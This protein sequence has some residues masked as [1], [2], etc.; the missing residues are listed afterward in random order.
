MST[1]T[2]IVSYS[3]SGFFKQKCYFHFSAFCW[4]DIYFVYHGHFQHDVLTLQTLRFTAA[5]D[6]VFEYAANDTMASLAMVNISASLD[7]SVGGF[8]IEQENINLEKHMVAFV[9]SSL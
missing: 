1:F 5:A 9:K 8:F 6:N 3:I 7:I 4:N 2:V